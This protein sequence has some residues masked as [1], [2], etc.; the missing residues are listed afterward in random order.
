V[1]KKVYVHQVLK[2]ILMDNAFQWIEGNGGLCNEADY[3]YVSG[4]GTSPAC[5]NACQVIK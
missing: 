4:E 5:S 3:P 2:E 1:N